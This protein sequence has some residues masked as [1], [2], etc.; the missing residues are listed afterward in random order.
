MGETERVGTDAKRTES[1]T[2]LINWRENLLQTLQFFSSKLATATFSQQTN[3][4]FVR[5]LELLQENVDVETS[6]TVQ[7]GD[8]K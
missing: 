2:Y 6:F 4:L 7:K 3:Y 8:L 5:H 1:C